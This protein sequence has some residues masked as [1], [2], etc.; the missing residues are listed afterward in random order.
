MPR[1]YFDLR[2]D[3]DVADEEGRELPDLNSV[4]DAAVVEAREMIGE[5]VLL[6][7]INLNH[8]IEVRDESGD[9]VLVMRFGD[10]VEVTP[11]AG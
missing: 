8:R 5:S 7:R 4:R 3:V 9:T 10:A 1:Y 6:G 11:I 2:N